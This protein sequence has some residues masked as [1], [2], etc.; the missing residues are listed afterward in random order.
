MAMIPRNPENMDA[1]RDMIGPHHVDQAIRQAISA[2]WMSLPKEKRSV[3]DV[4]IQIRRLV[5]RALKNMHED[6]G[7]FGFSDPGEA[8]PKP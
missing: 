1:M 2:R 6:A 4:E 5:D 3:A 7:Q 8:K